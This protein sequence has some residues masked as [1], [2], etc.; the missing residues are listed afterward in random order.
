MVLLAPTYFGITLPSSVFKGLTARRL[1][2]SFGVNGLILLLSVY[3]AVLVRLVVVVV[4]VVVVK[5]NFL[6]Y[7]GCD[8][9]NIRPKSA[10]FTQILPLTMC[11]F[12]I[13]IIIHNSYMFRPY[14][15]A[16]F[17]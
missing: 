13:F 1:Y 12:L 15:L 5:Q 7:R 3:V 14:I 4:V 16:I 11:T 10:I 8:N 2:K 17:R 9:N 6:F